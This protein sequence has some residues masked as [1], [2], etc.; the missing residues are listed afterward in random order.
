LKKHRATATLGVPRPCHAPWH[1]SGRF[2]WCLFVQISE[3]ADGTTE[4]TD[5]KEFFCGF[6]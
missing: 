2:S 6:S 1:F 5:S 3:Q 4:K